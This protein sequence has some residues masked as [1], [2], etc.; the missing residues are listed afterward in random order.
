MSDLE[1]QIDE[2]YQRPLSAFT[3]ARQ[4]LAKSLSGA[5]AKADAARVKA[6]VKPT[7]VPWAVNQVYWRAR[8]IWD[9]L[10]ATG[11]AVRAHQLA[12]LS[13][14]HGGPGEPGGPGKPGRGAGTADGAGRGGDDV[15]GAHRRA[16]ADAVHQAIRAA[17]EVGAQPAVDQLTRMFEALSL[18]VSP[19]ERPGRFTERVQ[20]AGF[21]ALLGVTIAPASPHTRG[22]ART[23]TPASHGV[24]KRSSGS[25]VGL[26]AKTGASAVE[27]A[28]RTAATAALAD[29]RRLEE[30]ARRTES[31]ATQS[32]HDAELRL[33]QAKAALADA[34]AETRAAI[35]ARE[36]AE[37]TLT[38]LE[39][40]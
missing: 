7:V 18:V 38:R 16:V 8:S 34:Q 5:G 40:V 17:A 28:R 15:E 20:P 10:I 6:L 27:A 30:A 4:A 12:V 24:A 23:L 31:R 2:L 26:D 22:G 39:R 9:R 13:G 33:K 29:A 32:V 11:Q 21:E 3:S 25:A 37:Q 19:A 1:R 35:A 36:K 14:E